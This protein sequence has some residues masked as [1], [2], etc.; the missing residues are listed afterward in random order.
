M[1]HDIRHA[2]ENTCPYCWQPFEDMAHGLAD[3][4]ADIIDPRREPY[5]R[6]NVRWCCM[7]CNREK[8]KTDPD[9]W[10]KKLEMWA[11]WRVNQTTQPEQLT[12]FDSPAEAEQVA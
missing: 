3:L 11:R 10:E 6:T 4:T 5:Y 8:Q 2:Y 1:T 12:F 7:T 9:L